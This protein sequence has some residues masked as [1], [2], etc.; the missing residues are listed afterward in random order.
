M[1][2][3]VLGGI[4]GRRR[5]RCSTTCAIGIDDVQHRLP[6]RLKAFT[7]AVLGGIGNL[8]GALLGG[9]LLGVVENYG[10]APVRRRVGGRHRLRGA[11]R[12]ADVPAHRPARRVAGEGPRMS[13]RGSLAR[14]R[15]RRRTVAASA[16]RVR[17]RLRRGCRAAPSWS[18]PVLR[19]RTLSR[20]A[21]VPLLE[22]TSSTARLDWPS[23]LFDVVPSTCL[24]ALGL[25]VVVGWPACS[26]SATS[27]SSPSA[28]TPS[29]RRSTIA[30][31]AACDTPVARGWSSVPVAIAIA[32]ISGVLL[33]GRRCGCAATTWPSSRWA[34]ARS[35]GSLAAT[36]DACQRG[37]RGHHQTSRPART[38]ARR[39][40]RSSARSTPSRVLARR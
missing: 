37:D 23:V 29:A 15:T 28:P 35:S 1:L 11:G 13:A 10:A 3:F 6:A 12:G 14:R 31:T 16:W 19:C 2:I 36:L 27:A 17:A 8:R 40:R 33:G 22:P 5:R 21:V 4:D 7:A 24:L 20:P 9:L 39:R 30:E 25:N 32:M 18:Y 26:T 38:P 34:S